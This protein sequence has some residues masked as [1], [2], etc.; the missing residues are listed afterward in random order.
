MEMEENEAY[1]V[2]KGQVE[3]LRMELNEAYDATRSA[4]ACALSIET[5]CNTL[6][7]S[8]IFQN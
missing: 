3:G 2:E 1:D 5:D 4:L 7:V 8:G 6:L